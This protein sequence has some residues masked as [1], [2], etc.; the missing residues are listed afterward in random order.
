[1]IDKIKFNGDFPK[2]KTHGLGFGG[3]TPKIKSFSETLTEQIYNVSSLQKDS[4]QKVQGLITGET[5]NIHDVTIAGQK[6]KI[7]FD[8]MLEVRKKLLEGYQEIMRTPV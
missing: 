6:S 3:Q 4:A 7:A 1:M 5:R 2:L 8:L